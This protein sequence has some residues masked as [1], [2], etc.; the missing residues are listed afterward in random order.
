[1]FEF[2]VLRL[3]LL[4]HGERRFNLVILVVFVLNIVVN[5]GDLLPNHK[6]TQ[7]RKPV[8]SMK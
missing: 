2:E 3:F 1:M 4:K 5:A 6:S 8:I 7:P